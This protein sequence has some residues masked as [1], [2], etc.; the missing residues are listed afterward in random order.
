MKYNSKTMPFDWMFSS[1][2]FIK[3]VISNDF[4][5]LL[6]KENIKSKNPCWDKNASYN[7]LY[8]DDILKSKNITNHLLIKKELCDYNNFHMWRHYN[9]LEEEQYSKYQKYV[10]RFRDTIKSEEFKIFLYIQYYDNNCL[11]EI[12]NFNDFLQKT[13][14]N[15]KFVCIKCKKVEIKTTDFVCSYNNKN[16]HIYDLEVCKYEDELEEKDLEKI[17][18]EMEALINIKLFID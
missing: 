13:V 6:N 14:S 11:E 15:Y 16:L 8:N 17:K 5:L 2:T 7:V 4:G 10:N 1:L 9:L 18:A 12:F 3:D